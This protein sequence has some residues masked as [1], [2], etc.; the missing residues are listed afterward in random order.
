LNPKQY[1]IS[2]Q[3]VIPTNQDW[4][5]I[6]VVKTIL[7]EHLLVKQKGNWQQLDPDTLAPV[8]FPDEEDLKKLVTDAISL[9]TE[10]YGNIKAVNGKHLS[11][12]TGANIELNW[13]TLSFTQEGK[14]T[15]IINRIYS[16]HYLEWTGIAAIDKFLG[17]FGLILMIVITYTG[18]RLATGL[19]KKNLEAE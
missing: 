1:P 8:A 17:V 15:R 18:F 2:S 9:N 16:I 3:V 14:D 13:E 10:R 11:T 7:G 4:Q 5:E 6:R 19:D 12:D